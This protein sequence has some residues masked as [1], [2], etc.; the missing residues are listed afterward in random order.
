MQF[1]RWKSRQDRGRANVYEAERDAAC[2]SAIIAFFIWSMMRLER[3]ILSRWETVRTSIAES[4][5]QLFRPLGEGGDFQRDEPFDQLAGRLGTAQR[6]AGHH[7]A[8][9]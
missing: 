7:A 2:A 9:Q 8:R 6:V 5:M 1:F 4:A 3:S